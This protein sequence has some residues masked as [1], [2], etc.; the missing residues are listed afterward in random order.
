M[1]VSDLLLVVSDL[2]LVGCVV[3]FCERVVVCRLD[4]DSVRREGETVFFSLALVALVFCVDEEFTLVPDLL[5]E[6]DFAGVPRCSCVGFESG[7]TREGAVR[8]RLAGVV[9]C[10]E[11]DLCEEGTASGTRTGW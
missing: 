6:P 5:S 10:F 8:S 3:A 2:L 11:P 1:V 7:L 4:V 9:S